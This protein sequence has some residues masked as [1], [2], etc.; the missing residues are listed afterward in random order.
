MNKSDIFS[1]LVNN[2]SGYSV[3]QMALNLAVIF[4]LSLF[5]F[6]VYRLT[7][8]R[9]NY[10][11]NFAIV[12]MLTSVVTGVIMMIIESNLVLSLGMVG[13]LSII[14]FR[15]AIKDP[16]DT[17]YIFWAVAV[18]IASGTG[19]HVLSVVASLMIAVFVIVFSFVAK[20]A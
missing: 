10:Y 3:K 12:L 19:N 5:M 20:Q 7:T 15:S 2:T 17:A 1:Y 16:V 4:V 14:R 13:A 18:G 9:V 11:S 8:K 6:A